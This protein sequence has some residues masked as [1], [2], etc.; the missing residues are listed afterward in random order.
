[1]T[2]TGYQ[3]TAAARD[4]RPEAAGLDWGCPRHPRGRQPAGMGAGWRPVP[5]ADRQ[6]GLPIGNLISQFFAN[7]YLNPLDNFV[8][9]EL[10]VKGYVRYI[11]DFI[12]F[13]DDRRASTD[14]GRHVRWKHGQLH[15][16]MHPD[17]YR[18][19]PTRCGADFAGYVVF[20]DG[21]IRIRSSR[22]RRFQ[23]RYRHMFR[24]VRN[25]GRKASKV[26]ESVRRSCL[27]NSLSGRSRWRLSSSSGS[28]P[29]L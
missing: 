5:R 29:S 2:A 1:M 10:R 26:T 24:E 9:H 12:L 8:K 22:V 15:L 16:E 23:R 13:G 18:L 25:G 11:D 6:G 19:I 4:R 17:K 21:R 3:A 14:Q 20:A 7:V 28:G 27:N